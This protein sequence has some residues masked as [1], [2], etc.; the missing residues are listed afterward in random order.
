MKTIKVSLRDIKLKNV[1][2]GWAY[3][4][5]CMHI[6]AYIPRV[7]AAYA[8]TGSLVC[9]ATCCM[10]IARSYITLRVHVRIAYSLFCY[11][12]APQLNTYHISYNS[13]MF[14]GARVQ[15]RN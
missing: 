13:G 6:S 15:L 3:F 1:V 2:A 9:M 14:P 4:F 8:P 11:Y 12:N 10:A 5:F 7:C